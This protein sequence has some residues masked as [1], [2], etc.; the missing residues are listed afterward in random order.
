[1]KIFSKKYS[2][3]YTMSNYSQNRD[4]GSM[5]NYTKRVNNDNLESL[6]QGNQLNANDTLKAIPFK[7][8]LIGN[9]DVGKT[10]IVERYVNN[11]FS[12]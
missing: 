9:S 11:R 6:T 10:C 1:M 8:C 12:V 3:F 5:N 4:G 2:C 7:L